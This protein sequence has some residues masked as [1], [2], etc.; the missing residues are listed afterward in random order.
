MQPSPGD[1]QPGVGVTLDN[2]HAHQ[3]ADGLTARRVTRS[4][5]GQAMWTMIVSRVWKTRAIQDLTT[6]EVNETKVSREEDQ[7]DEGA[8]CNVQNRV[9]FPY[10]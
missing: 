8:P 1:G 10:H 7:E 9:V 5:S 3:P 2:E 6:A 4:A